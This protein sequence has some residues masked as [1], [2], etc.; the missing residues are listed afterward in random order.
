MQKALDATVKAERELASL[1]GADLKGITGIG[2][3]WDKTGHPCV[4]VDVD[5]A[6]P[7]ELVAKIPSEIDE[8]PV[9]VMHVGP[10]VLE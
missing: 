7:P 4:R 8:V 1:F 10:A 2:V 6:M 5:F 3:A 9:Q